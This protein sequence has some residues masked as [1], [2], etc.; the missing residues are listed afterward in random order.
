MTSNV[1]KCV[2][3]LNYSFFPLLCFYFRDFA[4]SI[5]R[6]TTVHAAHVLSQL[7]NPT[8]PCYAAGHLSNL[9]LQEA[10]AQVHLTRPVLHA[11]LP[12]ELG[13]GVHNAVLFII[14]HNLTWLNDRPNVIYKYGHNA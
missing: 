1:F 8:A 3:I 13:C 12:E 5:N 9:A 14:M 6:G 10:T 7:L 4:P 2:F 11:C